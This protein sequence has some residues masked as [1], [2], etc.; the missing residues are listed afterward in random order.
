MFIYSKSCDQSI[1]I[2]SQK[3]ALFSASQYSFDTKKKSSS[4]NL[5]DLKTGHIKLLT[6]DANVSEIVWLGEDD[7]SVLYINGTNA[8]IPGGVE[9]WVSDVDDF[10]KG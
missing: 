6:D 2:P 1:L 3:V 4:W 8:E 9:L 10:S 5:L 7:T